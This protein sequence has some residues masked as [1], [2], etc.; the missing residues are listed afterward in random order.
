[1]R[2]REGREAEKAS[3]KCCKEKAWNKKNKINNW[4]LVLWNKAWKQKH[5]AMI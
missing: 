2:D 1:M 3:T 4:K 5:K